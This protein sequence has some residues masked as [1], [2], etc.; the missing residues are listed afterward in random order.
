METPNQEHR[1][2]TSA[3]FHYCELQG[4]SSKTL[5][6]IRFSINLLVRKIPNL[7]EPSD[8]EILHFFTSGKGGDLTGTP[9]SAYSGEK[10]HRFR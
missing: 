6:H 5:G 3:F 7:L 9:W 1:R 8:D 2:F 10:I 4:L